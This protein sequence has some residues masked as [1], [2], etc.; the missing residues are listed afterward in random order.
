MGRRFY[1]KNMQIPPPTNEQRAIIAHPLRQ[2]A[3]VLAVAG[4]GKTT[5]IVLRVAHLIKELGVDPRGV[6]VFAYNALARN[7]LRERI[8]TLLTE[9][10]DQPRVDTFHSFAYRW[11]KQAIGEQL[12]EEPKE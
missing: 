12:I 9:K 6:R 5:T 11:L 3:R 8:A 7:E 4:S 1:Q 10:A 2:H